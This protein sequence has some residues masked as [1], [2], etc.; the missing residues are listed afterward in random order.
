SHG[1]RPGGSAKEPRQ[2][3][4]GLCGVWAEK[5]TRR[6][7]FDALMARRTY[8]LTGDRIVLRFAV[9]GEP[10]G[11]ELP[12][13]DG[14]KMEI[15]VWGTDTIESVQ[16]LRNGTVIKGNAPGSDTFELEYEEKRSETETDFYH[17]RVVQQNGAKAVCS[18]VWVG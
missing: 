12:P 11:T 10:M 17:C 14:R 9:N 6:S 1:G 18:P 16:L 13:T 2:Y 15:E 8:A 4:G 7:L 5:L 3:W